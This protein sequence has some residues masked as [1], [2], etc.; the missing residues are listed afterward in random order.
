MNVVVE[1][2]VDTVAIAVPDWT[3]RLIGKRVPADR[4]E[5]ICRDGLA[6]PDFHLVTGPDNVP[7]G[8]LE[9]TGPHTGFNNGLAIPAPATL[10]VLPWLDRT[11]L[12]L[13]DAYGP[14]GKIAEM[15]P[16]TILRRQVERMSTLGIS[17]RAAF[18][19]EFF[20]FRG[21]YEQARANDYRSMHPSYHLHGDHDLLVAGYDE[22]VIG[23][24]RRSMPVAGVPV[25]VSQGEGGPG[26]HEI[27][28]AHAEPIEAADR[29]VVYKH[30]VKEIAARQAMAATFMA[31]V[32][33]SLPGS[34]CHVHVS[35]SKDDDNALG[36]PEALSDFGRGFVAGV[37]RYT[38]GF[39][40][41]HAPYA[42]SY[43]RLVDGSWAPSNLTW[44]HDNRTVALRML[45]SRNSYR[46]EFRVPG[47]DVNPYLSLAGFI[48]AGLAGVDR[49]DQPPAPIGGDGY[50]VDAPRGPVDLGHAVDLFAESKVAE[51]ALGEGVHRHL[52]AL[53]RHEFD[54]SRRA[55]TDWDRRRGFE[56]A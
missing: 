22:R 11:A 47:A 52:L 10:R 9:V 45:G 20:L 37:L 5:E 26:Q 2:G 54:A 17:L 25:E 38:P 18:E 1:P 33:E 55:V 40:P 31:K 27:S 53:A 4:F 23:E 41:L 46:I 29:H 24:I 28:L 34:S 8:D 56:R 19:L 48:A 32:D 42:N 50:G 7:Y 13:C 12:V 21:T 6:M 51:V 30:G 16:R 35:F 39:M 3:G 15:A 14:D 36:D 43:R 44:G 49:G